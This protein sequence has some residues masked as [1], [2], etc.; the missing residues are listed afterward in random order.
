M[1][2]W[3]AQTFAESHNFPIV[4][5]QNDAP[6]VYSDTDLNEYKSGPDGDGAQSP[7]ATDQCFSKC[8]AMLKKAEQMFDEGSINAKQFNEMMDSVNDCQV[9]WTDT[10]GKGQ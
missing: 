3:S 5:A 1:I 10:Q 8:T 6:R 4:I 9:S 7:E 2:C